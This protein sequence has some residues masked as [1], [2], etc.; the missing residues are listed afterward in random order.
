MLATI[1]LLENISARC[2]AGQPLN[3]GQR[4]WLG[5]VLAEY[6]AHRCPT[7][8]DA[9]QLRGD[10]GGIP[11]WREQANRKRD[12]ALR[13]L[14]ARYFG[15]L[16]VTAQAAQLRVLTVRYAA[17]TWRFDRKRDA[18]PTH[19]VGCMHE[20]LW[21]AFASGAPM[22][23]GERQLRNILPGAAAAGRS[24]RVPSAPSPG[25]VPVSAGREAD[26]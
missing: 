22:P 7:I 1:E 5:R 6:L 4:H 16:S 18:M 3:E 24:G 8:E 14:A 19:Y 9:M 23:I 12:A 26:A 10:R 20:W 13:E 15:G 21:R 2:L 11:W 25:A 17:S